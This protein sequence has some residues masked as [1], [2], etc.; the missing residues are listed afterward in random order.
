[1]LFDEF[2]QIEKAR[3]AKVALEMVPDSRHQ[4]NVAALPVADGEPGENAENPEVPLRA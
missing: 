3:M 1:M 4:P 2:R